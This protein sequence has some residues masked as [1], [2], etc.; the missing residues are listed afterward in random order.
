M[1]NSCVCIVSFLREGI[2]VRDGTNVELHCVS[3]VLQGKIKFGRLIHLLRNIRFR[4]FDFMELKR[5]V[6]YFN[7][8]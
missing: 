5:R 6:L 8:A 2:R 1:R 7:V 3:N 4:K